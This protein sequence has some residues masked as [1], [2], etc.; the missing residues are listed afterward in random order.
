MPSRTA[1]VLGAL[2]MIVAALSPAAAET[3]VEETGW[4]NP[5]D[6]TQVP[7]YVFYDPTKARPDGTFPAVLF[8]HA[9]RGLQEPDKKYVAEI[10]GH[11]F[12]VLAPDWQAGRFIDPWPVPHDPATELDVALG[13]GAL[14]TIKGVR[15]GERRVLYGYSRGGYYAVRIA[16]GV[17]D[18]A[19]PAEIACLVTVAGHFQN[20]NAPE[21]T[22]VYGLMPELDR[23]ARPILM[24][25]GTDDLGLRVENNARA[26]YAL[27]ERGH[28]ADLILLPQARRAFD[29]REYIDGSTV[30][31]AEKAAKRYSMART[32]AFMRRC[33]D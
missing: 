7:A 28:P 21:A 8:I 14:K 1:R 11:G 12:L 19:H 6:Q 13:L 30:T 24:V 4:T 9:R 17:I 29:F 25:I 2:A 5:K 33:L 26:F 3:R 20:P 10:A 18:S 23:L 22:Q 31:P 15:P 32:V 27:I 16:T